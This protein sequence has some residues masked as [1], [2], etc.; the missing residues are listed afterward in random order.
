MESYFDKQIEK[1]IEKGVEKEKKEEITRMISF[2][3]LASNSDIQIKKLLISTFQLSNEE[4][5]NY[6]KALE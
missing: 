2:M 5:D 1:G 6:L 3:R 4:A